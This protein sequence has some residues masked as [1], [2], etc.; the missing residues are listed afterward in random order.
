[1]EAPPSLP[2]PVTSLPAAIQRFGDPAAPPPAKMMAAKGLVPVKGA[3]MVMLLVQLSADTDSN[4]AGPARDTLAGLPREVLLAACGGEMHIAALDRLAEVYIED[5]EVLE[6]LMLNGATATSTVARVGRFCSERITEVIATNQQRLLGSP[7][8]IEALYKNTKTR[9]STADRLIELAAR[10]GVELTGI[11][12]F[13]AHVEAIQGELIPE[14]SDEPLPGDTLFSEALAADSD[15][16][17]VVA[18]DGAEDDAL[19]DE[20]KPLSF[21]IGKMR[22]SE[23][24]RLAI[25]GNAAARALLIRDRNKQVAMAAVAS[26]QM[27]DVEAVP[28]ARSK[29]VS[30]EILRY[31]AN[32]REWMKN[33]ELKRAIV[34]NP[35]MPTGI[36]LRYLAHMMPGDLKDLARSKNVPG[37]LKSAALQ[38][39]A[40]V[41]KK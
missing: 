39:L 35:K 40:K 41:E 22:T 27:T 13:Q 20:F 17:D 3:D 7:D 1:M 6:R 5:D 36:S 4:V 31:V 37:A 18:E 16:P 34:F 11:P 8:I 23:K 21:R 38:R 28:I 15:N 29:E 26:P 14:P 24:L 19:K 32:R 30:E 10:N 9:M 2:L 12:S 25:V 33:Y